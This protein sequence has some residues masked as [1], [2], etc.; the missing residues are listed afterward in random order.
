MATF[1]TFKR[2]AT[3]FATFASARKITVDTGLTE[4]EARRQ[5][6]SFNDNRTSAQIR[7]GTKMEYTSER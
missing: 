1:K 7:R 3:S 5:C 2:S 4:E 6:K